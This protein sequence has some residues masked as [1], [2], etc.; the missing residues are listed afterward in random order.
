MCLPCM[1]S[2]AVFPWCSL[3]TNRGPVERSGVALTTPVLVQVGKGKPR[4]FS[5]G[6]G[7]YFLWKQ[8]HTLTPCCCCRVFIV[9]SA[10]AG[11]GWQGGLQLSSRR[12]APVMR[13][14]AQLYGEAGESP[15]GTCIFAVVAVFSKMWSLPVSLTISTEYKNPVSFSS[16]SCNYEVNV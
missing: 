7:S 3:Q 9:S 8:T 1:C 10:M 13:L 15:R 12:A 5:D 14:R 6:Q 11:Q 4:S 2:P 16:L